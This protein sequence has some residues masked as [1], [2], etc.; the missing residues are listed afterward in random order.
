MNSNSHLGIALAAM[1]HVAAATPNLSSDCDTHYP[2]TGV[3][4]VEE[5][6]IMFHD[7]KLSL[8]NGPGLGVS[9][10][11]QKLAVLGDLYERSAVKDRD[12]TAYMKTRRYFL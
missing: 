2:W 6:P 5:K 3:D 9:L 12:D 7:G 1:N 4:V 11:R 10:D 8:P